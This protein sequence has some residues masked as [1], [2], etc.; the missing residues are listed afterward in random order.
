MAKQ[1][2]GSLLYTSGSG[3]VRENGRSIRFKESDKIKEMRKRAREEAAKPKLIKNGPDLDNIHARNTK[4]KKDYAKGFKQISV[5]RLPKTPDGKIRYRLFVYWLHDGK[6]YVQVPT[7]PDAKLFWGYA[8]DSCSKK[9]VG[10]IDASLIKD[11]FCIKAVLN[12]RVERNRLWVID[13]R[14]LVRT[15]P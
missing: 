8:L 11:S 13:I 14:P 7:M 3:H 4:Q 10:G 1:T 12:E 5:N 6:Y 15:I 2:S 9:Y